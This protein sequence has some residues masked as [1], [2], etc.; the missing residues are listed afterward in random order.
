MLDK[1]EKAACLPLVL[2]D[3]MFETEETV[4]SGG[5]FAAG[6]TTV[7]A[8][9]A[10]AIWRCDVVV[11]IVD[12]GRWRT[13]TETEAAA[14]AADTAIGLERSSRCC[15]LFMASAMLEDSKV[16]AASSSS[17]PEKSAFS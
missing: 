8:A 6:E 5:D 3:S 2:A 4:L 9:A 11:A 17:S 7:A 14:V 13:G 15:C 12:T 10:A 16:D 1:Y